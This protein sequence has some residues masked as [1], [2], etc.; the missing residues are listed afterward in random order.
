MSATRPLEGMAHLVALLI[1]KPR[2]FED[3]ANLSGLDRRTI[4]RQVKALEA[5]CLIR[6]EPITTG[7][8]GRP[9]VML[10]WSA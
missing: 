8:T 5:E 4:T 1:V 2:T 9:R 3:L 6:R 10:K 7:E